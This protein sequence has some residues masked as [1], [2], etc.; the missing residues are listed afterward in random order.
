VQ[1]NWPDQFP[2]MLQIADI[3]GGVAYVPDIK[4]FSGTRQTNFTIRSE[5]LPNGDCINQ[6]GTGVGSGVPSVPVL[7][8]SGFVPPFTITFTE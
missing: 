6:S 4:N 5:L 3:G 8:V 7:D 2:G 1:D